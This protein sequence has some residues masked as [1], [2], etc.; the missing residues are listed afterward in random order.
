MAKLRHSKLSAGLNMPYES[1]FFG[2][3]V[4]EF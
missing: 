2:Q 3:I 4:E 1:Q